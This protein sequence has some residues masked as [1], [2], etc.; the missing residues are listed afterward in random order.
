M[1]AGAGG[2][3]NVLLKSLLNEGDEVVIFAPYF[4]EYLFYIDNHGGKAV[5]A[6]TDAD[7][8]ID[9]ARLKKVVTPKTKAVIVNTPNNPTGAVYTDAEVEALGEFLAKCEKKFGHA[10]FLVSD[11]PYR[12]LIFDGLKNPSVMNFHDNPV[13]VYSHSK[14]L[15]LP[16]ERIGYIAISPR[17]ADADLLSGAC[18]FATRTLG[19]VNAPALMQRV[20]AP[21]Q[22]VSIDPR[23]YE[24]KRDYLYGELTAMGF[25]CIKP[26]GTFY[27]FPQ[28][29]IADD[30]EFV[31]MC[32]EEH[33]LVVPGSGFGRPGY[34]RIA[35]CVPDGVIEKSIP[36]FRTIAKKAGLKPGK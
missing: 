29:P 23:H 19:F 16:G 35:Y 27:I 5:V 8:R 30:V 4:V 20:C 14:D 33:V 34:F 26:R 6:E 36:Q 15:A 11:E 31:Q 1:S 7:F 32:L 22:H 13:V 21:L 2:G 3:M 28:C 12:R 24:R 18:T 9:I 10:I 25:K 17:M